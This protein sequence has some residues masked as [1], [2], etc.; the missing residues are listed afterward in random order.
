MLSARVWGGLGSLAADWQL[1]SASA[2]LRQQAVYGLPACLPADLFGSPSLDD[3]EAFSRAFNAALEAALGEA[4][5]GEIEVE[6]SSP[7]SCTAVVQRGGARPSRL[8]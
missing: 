4:A 2:A 3:I 5:A 1:L 6:V 8:L 7:V